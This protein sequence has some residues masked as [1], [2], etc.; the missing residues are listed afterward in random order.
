MRR[1]I[2]A[3]GPQL[4]SNAFQDHSKQWCLIGTPVGY[5]WALVSSCLPMSKENAPELNS[6]WKAHLQRWISE[7]AE[8]EEVGRAVS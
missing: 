4:R 6:R 1:V 8:L 2:A 7:L 3:P 5:Q